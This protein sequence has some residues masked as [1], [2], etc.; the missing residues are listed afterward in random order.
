MKGLSIRKNIINK[1]KVHPPK[2]WYILLTGRDK[3]VLIFF[4]QR[5][6]AVTANREINA[7]I[8]PIVGSVFPISKPI[9]RLAPTKPKITP[10]H[11]FN[12]IFSFNKGPASALVKTGW[13]VTIK[14]AIP[15]GSPIEIE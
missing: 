5:V 6:A 9:T 12:V 10:N 2:A 3:F 11:L 7:D 8:I 4:C 15:V 1:W 13:S 14:A